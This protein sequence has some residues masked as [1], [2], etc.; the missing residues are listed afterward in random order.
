MVCLKHRTSKDALI[1]LRQVRN[2]WL[3]AVTGALLPEE[4]GST[5]SAL[6]ALTAALDCPAEKQVAIKQCVQV[7]T[8]QIH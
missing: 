6:A 3:L 7:T 8:I 5:C 2:S 1:F 4:H